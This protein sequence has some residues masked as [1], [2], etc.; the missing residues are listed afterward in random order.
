MIFEFSTRF[1]TVILALLTA[2]A[3]FSGSFSA[4]ASHT[5]GST[6]YW[7]KHPTLNNTIILY[8]T[9][10]VA[11]SRTVGT[12]NVIGDGGTLNFTTSVNVTYSVNG[13]SNVSSNNITSL[14]G[15]NMARVDFNSTIENYHSEKIGRVENGV[16]VPGVI[17]TYNQTSWPYA[18]TFLNVCCRVSNISASTGYVLT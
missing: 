7:E 15:Q 4:E 13:T 6:I 5:R 18:L 9:T 3:Q 12:F 11:G 1:K 10:A 14:S 2:A 17:V 16:W 8:M